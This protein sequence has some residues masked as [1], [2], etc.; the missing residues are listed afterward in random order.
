M[1]AEVSWLAGAAA[2]ELQAA[3]W[4]TMGPPGPAAFDEAAAAGAVKLEDPPD[5][6]DALRSARGTKPSFVAL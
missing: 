1:A 5:T 3:G 6:P 4:A 2:G